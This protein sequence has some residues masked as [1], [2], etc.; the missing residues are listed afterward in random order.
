MTSGVDDRHA[1]VPLRTLLGDYPTT[2]ALRAGVLA[3]PLAPL[4]FAD[5]AVPNKA[6]KR[7][8][9]DLEFDVAELALMTFLMARSRDIPLRLL[10]VVVFGRNPLP[11]LVC[12]RE[13]RAVTPAGLR[14][15]RIGVR[16][17][18]TTAVWI[19]AMLA[20]ECGVDGDAIDWITLEEG[21]V[22]GVPDP[23]T[24]HRDRAGADLMAMLRDGV[25]DAAIVDPVPPGPRFVPVVLDPEAA[26]RSWQQRHGARTLN[27]V[28]VLRAALAEDETIVRELFR[29][30]RASRDAGGAAVDRAAT[31]F[32]LD[33][34]RRN[35]EVAIAVADA[36]RLLARPLVVDDLITGAMAALR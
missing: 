24:V 5:V 4:T 8:V 22:A 12:D 16:A 33:A 27:H 35:L 7:V 19:R 31:P 21:H 29:L 11:H 15:C 13:R 14:G 9:R 28:I 26:F 17:C 23:P 10:P 6:F 32:G 1:R 30:F 18:T 36:Q 2:H 20:D 3:S 34:N 25:V